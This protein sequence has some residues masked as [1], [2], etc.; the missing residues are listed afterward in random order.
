VTWSSKKV[1]RLL[2]VLAALIAIAV[3][4]GACGSGASD[5]S[6]ETEATTPEIEE[7]RTDPGVPDEAELETPPAEP[8]D[9]A[10]EA[11]RQ[12]S[13]D[14]IVPPVPKQQT[15]S[16]QRRPQAL[17]NKKSKSRA[18]KNSQS[19]DRESGQKQRQKQNKNPAIPPPTEKRISK[20]P[21]KDPDQNGYDLGGFDPSIVPPTLVMSDKVAEIYIKCLKEKGLSPNNALTH[22]D[23][24]QITEDCSRRLRR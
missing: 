10:E 24:Q 1:S 7:T 18:K 22:P 11:P 9:S 13:V 4:L 17:K 14:P 3:A 21:P 12:K 5:E 2:L 6:T 20:P 23:A 15:R 8:S 16:N 19:E